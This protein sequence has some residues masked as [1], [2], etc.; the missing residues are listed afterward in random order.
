MESVLSLED[1]KKSPYPSQVVLAGRA[2]FS[3][4]A[5]IEILRQACPIMKTSKN[6]ETS[7]CDVTGKIEAIC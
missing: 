1:A 7:A 2:L 3:Y 6:F 5:V 4:V